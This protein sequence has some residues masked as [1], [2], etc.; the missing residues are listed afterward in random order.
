MKK[1]L[2]CCLVGISLF[3]CSKKEA[4][5]PEK[6]SNVLLEEPQATEE[7]KG[8]E[9]PEG[10]TLIEGADCLSCHKIDSKL[11]GPSYQEIA[12]K[13]TEADVDKLAEKV[14]AGGKGSWGEVPM[15]AHPGMS[16]ETAQKMVKY[17]LSLKK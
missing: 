13:Y 14:I 11:V 12:N 8:E 4:E 2:L 16:K 6:E 5:N 9:K 15:T 3:S 7:N 17:I 1:L 10:L